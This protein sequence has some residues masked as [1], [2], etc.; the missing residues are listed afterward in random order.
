MVSGALLVVALWAD[1]WG[2]PSAFDDPADLP[3]AAAFAARQATRSGQDFAADAFR[4]FG[5]RDILWLTAGVVGFAFGLIVLTIPRVPTLAGAAVGFLALA[6]AILVAVTLISPPDY[7]E[8]GPEGAPRFNF[9]VEL[10]LSRSAGGFV[11]LAAALGVAIGA[12]LALM[13]GERSRRG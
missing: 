2:L 3:S 9:G 10:P 1:W 7:A 8:V 13:A 11:A 5:F 12:G 4:F 6:A